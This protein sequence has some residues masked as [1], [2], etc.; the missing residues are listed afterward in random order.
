MCMKYVTTNVY[1]TTE[2]CT[3]R[4]VRHNFTRH[5]LV[6]LHS[7]NHF[8]LVRESVA[9]CSFQLIFFHRG[10]TRI[11]FRINTCHPH[12]TGNF[13]QMFYADDTNFIITG[14]DAEQQAEIIYANLWDWVNVN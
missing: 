11:H 12:I 14:D 3:N 6:N 7:T 1:I 10:T 5:T 4:T 8:L 13:I 9:S 2:M